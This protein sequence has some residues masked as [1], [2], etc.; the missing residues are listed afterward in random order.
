MREL[1]FASISLVDKNV[2][3]ILDALEKS[4]E[5]DNTI[6]IFTSDHGEMLG[7]HN[8]YQ[9]MMP[10]DSCAKISFIIRYPKHFAPGSKCNDLINLNDILPT[11]LD[12]CDIECPGPNKLPGGSLLRDD[13]DRS[14]TFTEFSKGISR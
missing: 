8:C 12:V 13:M 14:H 7:D 1:Y 3:K 10:Y 4:G 9:K 2:G 5:M 6:I 11:I